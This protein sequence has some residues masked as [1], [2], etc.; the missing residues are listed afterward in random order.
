MWHSWTWGRD[1]CSVWGFWLSIGFLFPGANPSATG[2]VA[3]YKLIQYPG[4]LPRLL[5]ARYVVAWFGDMAS[6]RH[7]W[8]VRYHKIFIHSE[9]IPSHSYLDQEFYFGIKC[10]IILPPCEL[11]IAFGWTK[12][13]LEWSSWPNS[14]EN[15][16]LTTRYWMSTVQILFANYTTVTCMRIIHL[17]INIIWT[18]G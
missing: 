7:K 13:F 16:V 10:G 11:T 6:T 8:S 2:R 17:N 15:L 5:V 18:S 9:N 14:F 12:R 1:W 4:I 3:F